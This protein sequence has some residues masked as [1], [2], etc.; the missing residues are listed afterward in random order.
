MNRPFLH[1]RSITDRIV[2]LGGRVCFG[3]RTSKLLG[4]SRALTRARMYASHILTYERRPLVFYDES[5]FLLAGAPVSGE[6]CTAS[7]YF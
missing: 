2:R 4:A 1:A 5:L 6:L 7:I 3:T